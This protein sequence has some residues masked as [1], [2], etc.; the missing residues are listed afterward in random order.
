MSRGRRLTCRAVLFAAAAAAALLPAAAGGGP[1]GGRLA[2]V[3]S[4]LPHR[5]AADHLGHYVLDFGARGANGSAAG[6]VAALLGSPHIAH[7]ERGRY[8][9]HTS[10]E[11]LHRL[12]SSP[13]GAALRRVGALRAEHKLHGPL[14]PR[15][16]PAANG[17]TPPR[18]LVA[19]L[20]EPVPAETLAASLRGRGIHVATTADAGSRA[21]L[22][23]RDADDAPRAAR[24][25]AQRPQ[26]R[27]VETQGRFRQQNLVASSLVQS[28]TS[29]K[30]PLWDKGIDGSGELV[31]IGDTGLDFDSCFFEDS[32]QHVVF[33]PE[34]NPKHRKILTYVECVRP[35]DRKR[36]HED[37]AHSHGTHV[38]GSVA[39][40][41]GSNSQYNG[42]AHGAKIHFYDMACNEPDLGLP[43]DMKDYLGPGRANGARVSHNS[44]GMDPSPSTYIALDRETDKF[45]YEHQDFLVV[46]AAGNSPS[47][48]VLSP[49]NAKNALTVGAHTNSFE[50][51]GDMAGFSAK[52]P[53]WDQR[54]KPEIAAP[55]ATVMSA[56]SNGPSYSAH[57]D[58]E[59][60]S[61]TSMATPF[62]S[63]GAV[64]LGQ[65]FRE[66]WHPSGQKRA[67]DSFEP[68]AP[69]VKALLLTAAQ[70]MDG[71]QAD[72]PPNNKQGFGRLQ[73]QYATHFADDFHQTHLLLVNN[74]SV[75]EDSVFEVCFRANTKKPSRVSTI[76]AGL[77][78]MDPP[79]AEGAHAT[80][81][82]DLDLTVQSP[83]G[84]L[85]KAAGESG[86]LPRFDRH[87]LAEVAD[88]GHAAVDDSGVYRVSVYGYRVTEHS[89][90]ADGLPFAVAV[91]APN[92]EPAD[93]PQE[94]AGCP[95]SCGHGKCDA[96]TG[97]CKCDEHWGHVDCSE[98]SSLSYCHGNGQASEHNGKLQCECKDNFAGDRCDTCKS[99]WYGP[100]CAG[101]CKCKHGECDHD[102][103]HCSCPD[104]DNDGHW[105]GSNCDQCAEGWRGDD[106]TEP[107]HWCNDH[108]VVSIADEKNGWLQI[109]G[110][111]HYRN[112]L[113]CKWRISVPR[114]KK[115][116]LNFVNFGVEES[117]DWLSV[118]AG[119]DAAPAVERKVFRTGSGS[120]QTTIEGA[121]AV[122]IDFTSDMYD[123][124]G[125]TGFDCAF[126][127][128]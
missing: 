94:A 125:Q 126:S 119:P 124:G 25:L 52:G 55:G 95:S 4:S 106:C 20:S 41:S 87:N 44:W 89:P 116:S 18:L 36:F 10:P 46:V 3:L 76:R 63:G 33:Y 59:G 104:D 34:T 6:A 60:K 48:G 45:Q 30:H 40:H 78:W 115:I 35:A 113:D 5:T 19:V 107:S 97:R 82:N 90:Y 123:E 109:N 64:L 26:V 22:L 86:V 84:S 13:W 29:G 11:R 2:R 81:I 111:D 47:A 96:A 108:E 15:V 93:C 71:Y 23:L 69:L 38:S 91:S 128:H 99:G 54:R 53:T 88:L 80:L 83:D 103:G 92:V 9:A 50:R 66:G 65:Y 67:A 14:L 85:Q 24:L 12:A 51:P 101:D 57:C 21:H 112:S 105:G 43:I 121:S 1:R 75:T 17:S 117:Y 98:P 102:T 32:Q 74:A 8:V 39:G 56:A 100:D 114:G 122:F 70:P 77:V 49:A 120:F 31:V 7:L 42:I 68:S 58:V 110:A 27:W 72:H 28:T 16:A 73:M 118:F 37:R 61:G 127:V 62:V 79:P